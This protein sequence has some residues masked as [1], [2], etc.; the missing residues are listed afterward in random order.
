MPPVIASI[1]SLC[2]VGGLALLGAC[3]GAK[4]ADNLADLD[5]KLT[6]GANEA[7]E[8]I[9][10]AAA[11]GN[12]QKAPAAIETKSVATA[13]RTLGDLA[14]QQAAGKSGQAGQ[15]DCAKNVKSGPDWAERMP[16]PFR[17]YPGAKLQEAA[18]LDKEQCNLRIVSFTT[19]AAVDHIIDYY[20]T[21]ARQAGYDG[22]HLLSQGEHQLG[23]TREKDGA[24]YVVFARRAAGGETEVDIVANAL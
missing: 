3:G 15:G 21:T 9:A 20:Y 14:R 19:S 13:G 6:N 23:G 17:V 7:N 10:R 11:G 12:I 2:L 18:G 16:A 8:A 5:A 22:E 4:D 1:R 24:A